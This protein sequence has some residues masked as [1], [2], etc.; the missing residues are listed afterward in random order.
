MT[1]QGVGS[2]R[3]TFIV[4]PLEI[5]LPHFISDEPIDDASGTRF[6]N[7]KLSLQSVI[8][9]RGNSLDSGHYV[10]L[11]RGDV[12]EAAFLATDQKPP[13]AVE[14]LSPQIGA[15]PQSKS[16]VS[17]QRIPTSSP[18]ANPQNLDGVGPVEPTSIDA[19]GP[20]ESET[21]NDVPSLADTNEINE[22][23]SNPESA[24]ETYRPV[25]D[26]ETDLPPAIDDY[27]YTR[28][29]S[30]PWLLFD[31]LAKERVTYVDIRKALRDECPYL[32]FYQVQAIDESILFGQEE[33]PSYE[34][35]VGEEADRSEFGMSPDIGGMEGSI[36]DLTS[37]GPSLTDLNVTDLS[38]LARSSVSEPALQRPSTAGNVSQ[39][40]ESTDSIDKPTEPPLGIPATGAPLHKSQS[41]NI[42]S[43]Q[44]QAQPLLGSESSGIHVVDH[45]MLPADGLMM[46][47]R[48]IDLSTLAAASAAAA[49]NTAPLGRNSIGSVERHSIA[50]TDVDQGS[51]IYTASA[52]GG[53]SAPITPGDEH[54]SKGGFLGISRSRRG[55]V[56]GGSGGK[57]SWRR[58][59]SRPPSLSGERTLNLAL[60]SFPGMSI[61]RLKAAVSSDKLLHIK[62]T[63][64]TDEGGNTHAD[65]PASIPGGDS[66]DKHALKQTGVR[67]SKSLRQARK[68][69]VVATGAARTDAE[70]K[71]N[72]AGSRPDRECAIM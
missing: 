41:V 64:K 32:L 67:R 65:D 37:M 47:P 1:L 49:A 28:M 17:L 29:P 39:A 8:C 66:P 72:D 55:S 38:A 57:S 60:G 14:A 13:E 31:D 58:N 22:V 51:S 6:T 16:Q 45:A 53:S 4:I 18:P 36:S 44:H 3:S 62:S 2:R 19:V 56:T 42:A 70:R 26:D 23:P 59:R 7:F 54:D 5:G 50:L 52:K 34:S 33:P 10:S 71:S 21:T 30:S 20:P 35:V 46:R 15:I 24:R 43:L 9:H 12:T 69:K 48:S 11:V 68:G 27:A 61:G 40:I 25:G 63:D